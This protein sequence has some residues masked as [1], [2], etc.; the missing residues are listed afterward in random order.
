MSRLRRKQMHASE[1]PL[2]PTSDLLAKLLRSLARCRQVRK[3]VSRQEQSDPALCVAGCAEE[4]ET[5]A[6]KGV[7]GEIALVPG[8]AV[9]W[10]GLAELAVPFARALS[11]AISGGALLGWPRTEAG[12]GA[13]G[14]LA[15]PSDR[16]GDVRLAVQAVNRDREVAHARHHSWSGSGTDSR[17]I[18]R[19]GDV[20]HVVKSVFDTPVAAEHVGDLARRGLLTREAGDREDHVRIADRDAAKRRPLAG[21]QDRL[22][23]RGKARQRCLRAHVAHPQRAHFETTVAAIVLDEVGL[24]IPPVVGDQLLGE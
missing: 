12:E 14:V 7:G 18:L 24:A 20:S 13:R 15:A 3:A 1:F 4:D 8:R 21:D 19:E 11:L 16:A 9:R 5:Q 22:P 2:S 6:G 23:S 17:A 10:A